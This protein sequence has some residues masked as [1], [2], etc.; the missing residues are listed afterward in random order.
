MSQNNHNKQQINLSFDNLPVRARSAAAEQHQQPR[1]MSRAPKESRI[2]HW[3]VQGSLGYI[4]GPGFRWETY[5]TLTFS[6]PHRWWL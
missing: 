2:P 3:F 6:P 1:T 5:I 4:L